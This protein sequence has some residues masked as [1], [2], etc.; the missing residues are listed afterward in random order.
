VKYIGLGSLLSALIGVALFFLGSPLIFAAAKF[1]SNAFMNILKFIS[2]PVIFFSLSATIARLQ[3]QKMAGNLLFRTLGWTFF[4]T[5]IAASV[6]GFLYELIQPAMSMQYTGTNKHHSPVF[7]FSINQL[8]PDNLFVM[9]AQ[10]NVVAIVLFALLLGLVVTQLPETERDFLA[11]ALS[12]IYVL[13]L[14]MAQLIILLLPLVV[15]SFVIGLLQQESAYGTMSSL[16]GYLACVFGANLI[17]GLLILPILLWYFRINIWS[18][19]SAVSP[20]LLMAALTKS[21]TA[22][23]PLTLS[24]I[25]E[26]TDVSKEKADV[27][28]P[29]CATVNM[30]GCAAFIYV[31]VLFVAQVN[32]IDFSLGEKWLWVALSVLAAFGNAGVP[33][34]CFFMASAYLVSMN[35]STDMM[36]VILPF[37][38]LI[39]MMETPINIWSDV[40]VLSIIDRQDRSRSLFS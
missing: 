11:Q 22:S 10:H 31:T 30:N 18:L 25:E 7:D 33:M 23:L 28:L 1:T 20:A 13:F 4:T 16:A 35:I 27:I 2:L 29:L 36:G 17:Q 34:G 12:S 14:K 3:S 38:T 40:C 19:F 5:M 32:G 8:V 21:S 6:A 26:R 9:F 15:W 39:D 37:Y 24:C